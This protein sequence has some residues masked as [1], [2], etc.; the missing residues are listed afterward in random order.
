LW[1]PR[2]RD[3]GRCA[4]GRGVRARDAVKVGFKSDAAEEGGVKLFLLDT[5]LGGN[6]NTGHPYGTILTDE[7][8]RQLIEY[9]K[10]L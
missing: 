1:D 3:G 7:Q 4:D 6:A 9:L 5:S 2:G 10:T 8:K